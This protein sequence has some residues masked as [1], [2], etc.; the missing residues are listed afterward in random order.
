MVEEVFLQVTDEEIK[1]YIRHAEYF[2]FMTFF[3]TVTIHV[4]HEFG[5]NYKELSSVNSLSFYKENSFSSRT[6]SSFKLLKSF[7]C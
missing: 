1:N 5:F 4:N 7:N 3:T 2:F 6:P